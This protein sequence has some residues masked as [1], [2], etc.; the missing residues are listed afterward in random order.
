MAADRTLQ[1]ILKQLQS[2]PQMGYGEASSLLSRAKICLLKLN[3]LTPTTTTTTTTTTGP[4]QQQQQRL[5]SLARGVYEAGALFSIRARDPDAFTRYVAQLQPFYELQQRQ[6]DRDGGGEEEHGD[7]HE[8]RS[9]VTGLF[10]L[11]LLTQGRY[12]EFHSELEALACREQQLRGGS[13]GGGGAGVEIENDRYLG[14]PI[15][16]ERWLM[17]GSYDRVWKAM[18]SREVP[19]EEYGVF[20]EVCSVPFFFFM[21]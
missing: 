19:S 13:G 11:L 21:F 8:Q 1:G 12:A 14:Y 4:E 6:P 20:S 3:A 5:F 10:L 2:N 7:E 18:K 15:N 16:L 17:E 9:K